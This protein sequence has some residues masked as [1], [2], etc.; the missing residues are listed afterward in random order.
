MLLYVFAA[1]KNLNFPIIMLIFNHHDEG[2]N[3]LGKSKDQLNEQ[4]LVSRV[5]V[6]HFCCSHRYTDFFAEVIA[7]LL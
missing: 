3:T 2:P 4:S 5:C 1:E 6:W 7:E